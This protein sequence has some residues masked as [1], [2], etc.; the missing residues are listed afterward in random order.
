[1]DSVFKKG[2]FLILLAS[3]LVIHGQED[4][5]ETTNSISAAVLRADKK[6]IAF[7]DNKYIYLLDVDQFQIKDSLPVAQMENFG[8]ESLK[9]VESNPNSLLAKYKEFS[10]YEGSF[11]L[12]FDSNE[13]PQDSIIVYDLKAK[14]PMP[15]KL[16]GNVYLSFATDQKHYL[17]GY[18]QWFIP[19][20]NQVQHQYPIPMKG[21]I[22]YY[23]ENI[24]KPASG[25][26]RKIQVAPSNNLAA[27]VYYHHSPKGPDSL[28]YSLEIRNLP[29]M[30]I[31]E[32]CLLKG[33]PKDLEFN[34]EGTY[35]A[36]TFDGRFS[37][38]PNE[39]ISIFKVKPLAEAESLPKDLEIGHRI[40]GDRVW[41]NSNRQIEERVYGK[42]ILNTQIWSNLTP[43]DRIQGFFR[44]NDNDIIV[45]GPKSDIGLN[46][47]S[48]N[49]FY[50][51]SLKD[52][53][54]YSGIEDFRE[55]DTLFNP[56][57]IF[58]QNNRLEG[59]RI[60][61][62]QDKKTML[63]NSGKWLSWWDLPSRSKLH[64]YPFQNEIIAAF[65]GLEKDVLIFESFSQKS[66]SDFNIH[67]LDIE[68]GQMHSKA[69]RE[70]FGDGENIDIGT[71]EFGSTVRCFQLANKD[72]ICNDG[73]ARIWRISY[74]KNGGWEFKE[75]YNNNSAEFYASDLINFQYDS[76]TG[77]ITFNQTDYNLKPNYEEYDRRYGPIQFWDPKTGK[78]DQIP[79]SEEIPWYISLGSGKVAYKSDQS[80]NIMGRRGLS[81]RILEY[82]SEQEI[83]ILT[84]ADEAYLISWK[85]NSFADS[86][87]VAA[88]H[89]REGKIKDRF[90]L[91]RES[92]LFHTA[93]GI[94]YA[95]GE[96]LKTYDPNLKEH[97]SWNLIKSK[98]TEK[99][100][101]SLSD[102]GRLLFRNQYVIDQSTLETLREI[103]S[104]YN[105]VILKGPFND[106]VLL[107]KTN[108]YFE[109]R[110]RPYVDFSICDPGDLE[111]P[112]W[113]SQAFELPKEPGFP[114]PNKTIRS[115]QGTYALAYKWDILRKAGVDLYLIDIPNGRAEKKTMDHI[116]DEAYFMG[117]EDR[118]AL[119]EQ[120]SLLG[121]NAKT[122]IYEIPSMELLHTLSGRVEVIVSEKEYLA[123][124]NDD[125][126][127]VDASTG[128]K[129]HYY[130]RE[131]LSRAFYL[132]DENLFLA[133]SLS[134]SLFIWDPQIQSPIK[135]IRLGRS[136]IRSFERL[137]NKL[138]VLMANSEVKVMDIPSLQLDVSINFSEDAE[139][140][141]ALVWLTPEGYFKAAKK[142]IRKYHFVR[143]TQA[144]PLLNYELFLNRPDI[145]LDKLGFAPKDRVAL[146][147][148]AYLKRLRRN[149]FEEHTDYLALKQPEVTLTNRT[150]IPLATN[151][152]RLDLN[153]SFSS[154]LKSL[155]VFINGVPVASHEPKPNE[156]QTTK[157]IELNS[158]ENT[159][160]I[161]GI[162]ENGIES[163]PV[164]F[165]ITNTAA[166]SPSRIHYAGIGVSRYAD[167]TMNLRYADKD[168]RRTSA[169]L[170]Y[171]FTD[172]LDIID[173]LLNEAVTRESLRQLKG[174][175]MQTSINDIVILS[176]SG[177]GLVNEAGNFYFATHDVNFEDPEKRGFSYEEI[178][179]LLDGIPA[180]RKLLLL[181]ACNSGEIDSEEELET[182]ALTNENIKQHLPEGAKG[183]VV[184]KS[185]KKAGLQNS[186]ELMQSL[187]YDLSRGNGSYIISAAGGREFAFESEAWGNGVFTYSFLNALYELGDLR[188]SKL[189]EYIYQNVT[190]L[191]G[192][193]QKPTARQENVE[194]DWVLK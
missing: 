119:Y 99:A 15:N 184:V 4:F 75:E 34:S 163:D 171:R 168:V 188:I 43:F 158:G 82:D 107:T 162:G 55:Q 54:T 95:D 140:N 89:Y 63:V 88:F 142:D 38:M 143:G 160:T 139:E 24:S 50:K 134:G 68:S 108:M 191:T 178:Q 127:K 10:F 81:K 106:K 80:L 156:S 87:E 176:F 44:I 116:V 187:F 123:V 36:L 152:P 51:Y 61:L 138:Y 150:D 167:S 181:D 22:T 71:A 131:W 7:T 13:Y 18:N 189:R 153:L 16:P 100:D 39:T 137:G 102:S 98:F 11:R 112:V 56:E 165:K 64:A 126:I 86:A 30:A 83:Q 5:I 46:P 193:K 97:L 183:S 145:I 133:G 180:R 128:E 174:K 104:F 122:R 29:D 124:K 42:E 157:S 60:K 109:N 41:S 120:D 92:F 1:M 147:R 33:V 121:N 136:E 117:S 67:L 19:N 6:E 45:Y 135:K 49:G 70:G 111:N 149:G 96:F 103:P 192:G 172:R 105:S 52:M 65:P 132:Q 118:L 175:L 170:S 93:E 85:A 186:F 35:L 166:V 151:N 12:S 47:N 14:Q 23:P 21:E 59:G 179:S 154:K 146:Y 185:N 28:R 73:E 27:L 48:K 32:T 58:I 141:T 79:G 76:N 20:N 26:I 78:I 40:I 17:Y 148:E 9:Y 3:G 62:F 69:F 25:I 182:V 53:V 2:L 177:H 113:T 66:Y 155:Q 74:S 101:L 31:Q 114:G 77:T 94:T 130:A 90:Q 144:F 72:W 37:K 8:I 194:W 57:E 129:T 159:V 84:G 169:E 173:T 161:V 164:A 115:P 110:E 125:L 190:E 91:P